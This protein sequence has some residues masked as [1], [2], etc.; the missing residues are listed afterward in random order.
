MNTTLNVT[1]TVTRVFSETQI[2]D[3]LKNEVLR[4]KTEAAKMATKAKEPVK[5]PLGKEVN[6]TPR[7]NFLEP[8]SPVVKTTPDVANKL[9]LEYQKKNM[10]EFYQWEANQ[11]S[12]W[13]REIEVLENQRSKITKKGK[14]S[15][16]DANELD[17]ID[18]KIEYCEDVLA[19][20]ENDY[21]ED[22]E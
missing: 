10:E 18:E 5:S 15:A 6:V 16:E 9:I 17:L 14:L 8:I 19:E 1:K 3:H 21:F 4:I 22:S 11:P 7:P 2:P 20:L 13:L 12:T